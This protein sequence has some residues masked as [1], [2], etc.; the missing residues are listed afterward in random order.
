MVMGCPVHCA[1]SSVS[2]LPGTRQKAFHSL[3][4]KPIALF[5]CWLEE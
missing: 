1:F 3:P 2:A 5:C 4:D